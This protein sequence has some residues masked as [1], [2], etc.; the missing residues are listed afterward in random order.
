MY[1]E[2]TSSE[3]ISKIEYLENLNLKYQ[4]LFDSS[5]TNEKRNLYKKVIV[6][7]NQDINYLRTAFKLKKNKPKK[8]KRIKRKRKH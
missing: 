5:E 4:S 3:I 2:L 6:E 1:E 8:I 7:N